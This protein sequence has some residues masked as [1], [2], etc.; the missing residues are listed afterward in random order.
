MKYPNVL[1]E[2]VNKVKFDNPEWGREKVSAFIFDRMS[3]GRIVNGKWEKYAKSYIERC[4]RESNEA[5]KLAA[6]IQTTPVLTIDQSEDKTYYSFEG[7]SKIKTFDEALKASKVDLTIWEVDHHVFNSWDV[8]LKDSKNRP[9]TRTNIQVKIWFK[10]KTVDARMLMDG[11][12]KEIRKMPLSVPLRRTA[13]AKNGCM[14]ELDLF[15][16]HFGKLSWAPETGE[17]YD[18]NIARDRYLKALSDLLQKSVSINPI[19]KVLFPIGNDFLHYDNINL[20]TTAGTHQDVDGRWQKMWVMSR[21][22]ILESISMITEIAPVEVVRI[23]SNHDLQTM[24]YMGDLLE[25]YYE[26]NKNVTIDNTPRYR[27]YKKYGKCGIG[28]THGNEE[29][30]TDLPLILMRETQKEWSDVEFIEI[31]VGHYHKKKQIN[32]LS[33]DE[34]NGITLRFM[35]ALSGTDA[36]HDKKGYVKSL[37]G[38]ESFTWDK[39]FGMINNTIINIL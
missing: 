15:D 28:Y 10:K 19:E 3:V 31:H 18:L 36:W 5:N 22:V 24:F 29:K 16:P 1:V 23:A 21:K 2:A 9:T 7:P 17:D 27:K 4:Y 35:R 34:R 8:T 39:E 13:K 32:F 6:S 14:L 25:A 12:L 20:T 26:N 37:K 11:F 33:T 30:H 38:C